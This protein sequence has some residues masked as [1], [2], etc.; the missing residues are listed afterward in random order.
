[1]RGGGWLKIQSAAVSIVGD[2]PVCSTSR[3]IRVDEGPMFGIFWS[4]PSGFSS[5]SIG[6]SSDRIAAAARL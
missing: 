3:M 1:M 5:V 4:V 2:V 6:C